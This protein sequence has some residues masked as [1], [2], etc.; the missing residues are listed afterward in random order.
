MSVCARSWAA[1]GADGRA[2][3]YSCQ[4]LWLVVGERRRGNSLGQSE[5]GGFCAV[6]HK[7]VAG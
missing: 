2:R 5:V 4:R 6:P 7:V 1:C 3:K